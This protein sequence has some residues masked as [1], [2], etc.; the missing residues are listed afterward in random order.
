MKGTLKFDFIDGCWVCVSHKPK[1]HGYI[2]KMIDGKRE[3]LHRIIYRMHNGAIPKGYEVHH[4]CGNKKCCTPEH[5]EVMSKSE[6]ATITG[7]GRNVDIKNKAMEMMHLSN[8]EI[9]DKLNVTMVTVWRWRK[10]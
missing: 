8:R 4:T 9:A 7:T 5:L 10:G 2:E 1:S 3:Y 6:H